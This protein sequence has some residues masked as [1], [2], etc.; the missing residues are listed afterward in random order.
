[1]VQ[2]P[3]DECAAYDDAI[4]HHSVLTDTPLQLE[5][6]ATLLSCFD[7]RADMNPSERIGIALR[8]GI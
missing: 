6:S 3:D 2:T 7:I 5:R 1:M 4:L 8:G